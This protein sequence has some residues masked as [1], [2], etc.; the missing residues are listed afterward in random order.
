MANGLIAMDSE[1]VSTAE[2]EKTLQ[3]CRLLV[4]PILRWKYQS[5]VVPLPTFC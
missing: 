5:F 2:R 1:A 4:K 3:Y